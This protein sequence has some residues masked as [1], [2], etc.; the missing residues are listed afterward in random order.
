[1]RPARAHAE[2]AGRLSSQTV[3]LVA[4]HDLRP[5]GCRPPAR[6]RGNHARRL[7]YVQSVDLEPADG[8]YPDDVHPKYPQR[9]P[10]P[11]V[12]G[13][14]TAHGYH[15]WSNRGTDGRGRGVTRPPFCIVRVENRE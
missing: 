11:K 9:F 3:T 14:Y 10:K 7:P 1:V 15:V 8:Q 2:R 6:A 5:R 12:G 4:A 13:G